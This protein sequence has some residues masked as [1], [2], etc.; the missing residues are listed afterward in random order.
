[1]TAK[2][3]DSG[4]SRK[5]RATKD[6]AEELSSKQLRAVQALSVGQAPAKVAK[7]VG[8]HRATIYRWLEEP[9]FRAGVNRAKKDLHEALQA[10]SFQL[11]D[12][13]M[14]IVEEELQG[15]N[16]EATRK[17]ETAMK[18]LRGS[19]F[20]SGAA[21]TIGPTNP[22]ELEARDRLATAQSKIASDMV[23][24]VELVRDLEDKADLRRF[25]EEFRKD[26]ENGK[27]FTQV[28]KAVAKRVRESS[29]G[30]KNDPEKSG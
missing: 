1:M 23:D 7:A 19:G 27:R 13:A 25:V 30:P 17:V 28:A 16:L 20:L 26:P 24:T 6:E 10:R 4:T 2:Q 29:D 15:E 18:V 9:K 3:P 8:V 21:P 12:T 5:K 11:V 22:D 14:R